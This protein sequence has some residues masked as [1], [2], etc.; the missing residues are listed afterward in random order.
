GGNFYQLKNVVDTAAV[1]FAISVRARVANEETLPSQPDN[2]VGFFFSVHTG[3]ETFTLG[4][5]PHGYEVL[6]DTL[7][8]SF[9]TNIDNTD[10][11]DYLLAGT[12]G[13][14]FSV[15]RDG[16]LLASGT[17]S[18]F[19]GFLLPNGLAFG[20]GS[21]GS[22]ATADVTSFVFTQPAAVPE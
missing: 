9:P 6:A 2:H 12:P 17:P 10:Y 14:E 19:P 1:P 20:D 8:T 7:Q 11:H 22:N 18:T 21:G 15:F 13:G 3:T 4:I 16:A 5:G